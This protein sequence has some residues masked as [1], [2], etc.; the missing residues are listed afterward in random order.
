MPSA[1]IK[2]AARFAIIKRWCAAL[3]PKRGA[4]RGV[5]G[6]SVSP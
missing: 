6:I 3:P 1:A 4:L 5:A 2:E